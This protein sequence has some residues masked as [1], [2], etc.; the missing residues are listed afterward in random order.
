MAENFFNLM[1]DINIHETEQTPIKIL[2]DLHQE[3]SN[4][5][6]RA[7]LESRKRGELL[8]TGNPQ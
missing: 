3:T 7:S 5:Q 1:I 4:F 6:K 8:H 2:K